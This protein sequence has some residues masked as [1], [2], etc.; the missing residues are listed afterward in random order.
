MPLV[1]FPSFFPLH[2]SVVSSSLSSLSCWV[3]ASSSSPA[4]FSLLTAF[5]ARSCSVVWACGGVGAGNSQGRVGNRL[6]EVVSNRISNNLSAIYPLDYHY[7]LPFSPVD[8]RHT[9]V[10]FNINATPR[11]PP[12]MEHHSQS[13]IPSHPSI[14]GNIYIS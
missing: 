1:H 9:V 7:F 5:C 11:T 3:C 14:V 8:S 12:T 10:R 13:T 6:G 2:L 4:Q